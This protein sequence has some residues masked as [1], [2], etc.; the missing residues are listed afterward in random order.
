MRTS[1]KRSFFARQRILPAG[2]LSF[3]L[4]AVGWGCQNG[5]FGRKSKAEDAAG[6]ER[7]H[8]AEKT[9]PIPGT[10]GAATYFEGRSVTHVVGYGLVG[11]LGS[12]G[13]SEVPGNI[14][15][16]IV[17]Q[18]RKYEQSDAGEGDLDV[19]IGRLLASKDTAVVR[20][21]GLIPAGGVRGDRFDLVVEALPNTGTTSLEDGWLYTCELRIYSAQGARMLRSDIWGQGSGPVFVN[22]FEPPQTAPATPVLQRRGFV[23]G[24]GIARKDQVIKLVLNQPSYPICRAIAQKIN[25]RFPPPEQGPPRPT[26]K[27]ITSSYIELQVPDAYRDRRDRFFSLVQNLL[28]RSE[29]AEV[30]RRAR[31]LTEEILKPYANREA[32]SYV[33]EGMPKS[34]IPMIQPLY[35]SSNVHAAYYS[36]R[37]GAA[38]GDDLGVEALAAIALAEGNMYQRPAV[39]ELG[40]CPQ[41]ASR[42]ALR[43]VLSDEDVE[44]RILAYE[45]LARLRDR[46]VVRMHVHGEFGFDIDLVQSEGRFLVYAT[47]QAVQ[48]LALFGSVAVEPPVFYCNSDSS[49]MVTAEPGDSKLTFVLKG[50][51]GKVSQMQVS[52]DLATVV[53]VMGADPEA[54][55]PSER[56]LGLSYSEVVSMVSTL[57]RG[58]GIPALF[59]MQE[60]APIPE[61]PGTAGGRPEA[62]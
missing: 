54:K 45:G 37:A 8:Q 27:A 28:V 5:L 31:E 24:G 42:R 10:V 62:G 21:F 44:R 48:R 61:T 49:L 15:Q 41:M 16:E 60:I 51:S 23:L 36:A 40:Y 57:C 52:R 6:E 18:L 17:D 47:R 32:I 14:R 22:P 26:A 38:L 2:L 39:V 43:R 56:G 4:L 7:K 3:V 25:D 1:R 34:I 53:R 35:R 58:G 13:S 11:G 50:P 19:R 59:R 33:W 12:R 30:T 46:A 55:E 29:P 20:V 9:A